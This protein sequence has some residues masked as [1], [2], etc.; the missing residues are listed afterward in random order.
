MDVKKQWMPYKYFCK[1]CHHK[2]QSAILPLITIVAGALTRNAL[3]QIWN[4]KLISTNDIGNRVFTEARKV[5]KRVS[6]ARRLVSFKVWDKSQIHQIHVP[7]SVWL[8]ADVTQK[9]DFSGSVRVTWWGYDHSAVN[10]RP[11]IRESERDRKRERERQ[12]Q[13]EDCLSVSIREKDNQMG[14]E[15][16]TIKTNGGRTKEQCRK[17]GLNLI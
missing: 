5:F 10:T 17:K 8:Q 7:L 16:T 1:S 2:D 14:W 15:C 3:T 6:S 12:R 13:T 4:N 11:H 9:D